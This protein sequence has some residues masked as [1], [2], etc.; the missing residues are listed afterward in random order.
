MKKLGF[1]APLFLSS[2]IGCAD[3]G[4]VEDAADDVFLTEDAK[5]DAFGVEDW[6]PDG[7]AVL[8]LVSSA[9][10]DKL[11]DEV[12]LSARVAKSIV[13]HR[14]TLSGGEYHDLAE[15]DAASYV[16]VTVFKRL[17]KY[18]ADEK[19]FR[20]SIRIPLVVTGGARD[21]SITT[22][23][24]EARTA[25]VQGFAAYTFVD[26]E[27]NFSE[28]MAK[29]DERLAELA[30]KAGI[31]TGEMS[32]YASSINDY[33]VGSLKPCYLGDPLEVVD[34]A[35]AQTDAMMGDMYSVWGWRYKTTK[36]TYED[37]PDSDFNFDAA[38]RNFNTRGKSVLIA[39]TNTDS[40]DEPN[41][42][43]IGPCR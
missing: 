32:M 41:S 19:L 20:T 30:E 17:L 39:A 14:A 5:A 3:D 15:L 4:A 31:E 18:V 28:K 27:T 1:L 37:A 12:G 36:W 33:A 34:V 7:R 24:D 35:Q 2:L 21:V 25:G 43:V 26:A 42:D 11:E 23:N 10:R 29:Y 13:A 6:S 22:F 38:W 8:R 16:G 40:G 9:S